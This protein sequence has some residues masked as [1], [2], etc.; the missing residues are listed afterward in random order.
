MNLRTIIVTAEATILSL[1]IALLIAGVIG[2]GKAESIP[3]TAAI[4]ICLDWSNVDSI[5]IPPAVKLRG[6]PSIPPGKKLIIE[7]RIYEGGQ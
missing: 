3:C 4:S 5:T 7:G 1:I 6:V 2:G